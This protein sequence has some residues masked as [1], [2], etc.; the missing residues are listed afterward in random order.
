M[1]LCRKK[2]DTAAEILALNTEMQ[3]VECQVSFLFETNSVLIRRTDT[4]AV[5]EE[6]AMTAEE[7]AELVKG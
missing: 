7:H 3:A 5:I 6:R 1:K 2:A 4:G